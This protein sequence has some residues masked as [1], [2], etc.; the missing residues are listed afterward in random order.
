MRLLLTT[1]YPDSLD[2]QTYFQLRCRLG[3]LEPV[4]IRVF[5]SITRPVDLKTDKRAGYR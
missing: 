4:P 2:V 5:D 1:V 3:D